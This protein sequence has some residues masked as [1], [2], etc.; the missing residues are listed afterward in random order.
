MLPNFLIIGA[1]KCGTTSLHQ[2]LSG[3]PD[4]FMH[5]VKELRFFS[6]EHNW[7]R[8]SAWYE[9]QFSSAG[10]A[11]AVGESSNAYSRHPVYKGVPERIHRLLPNVRLIYL[12][13]HPIR[14]IESH[15]RHRLVTGIEWRSPEEALRADPG[16]IAASRYGD[17]LQQY[18]RHFR[19]EQ[20]LTLRFEALVAD[21]DATLRRVCGFLNIREAPR[22][23]FPRSNVTAERVVAPAFLRNLS[24]FGYGKKRL[25]SAAKLLTRSR[26]RRFAQKADE[27]A[28]AL[29]RRQREE[30]A[31][32]L[33]KDTALLA[34]IAGE[35]FDEWEFGV[36]QLDGSAVDDGVRLVPTTE[37][38]IA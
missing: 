8:G 6:E 24:R 4:V 10:S 34:E 2:Y 38:R 7:W 3:H 28:F 33:R 31:V 14:R 20:M 15:Y 29:S 1:T 26:L 21:P 12:V 32:M 9:A 5:P 37:A 27:P 22:A 35:P 30:L 19:P 13:R 16:Y 25:M 23:E 17:Q 18:L 11:S 36:D